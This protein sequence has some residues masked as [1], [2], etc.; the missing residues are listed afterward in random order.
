SADILPF[1]DGRDLMVTA[2]VTKEGNVREKTPGDAQQRLDLETELIG[3]G[4]ESFPIRSGLRVSIY[5]HE[6]KNEERK[7]ESEESAASPMHLFRYGERLRFPAKLYPPHNFRNPG[8]F[9]YTG[10]LAEDGIVALG[11]T[12]M[13]T[14]E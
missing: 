2:H 14:V 3:M 4:S 7:N 12:E 13:E 10:Y 9:D 11:S 8:A 6:A 1:A 5:G